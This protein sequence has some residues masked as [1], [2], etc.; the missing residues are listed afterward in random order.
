[1]FGN[2][3]TSQFDKIRPMNTTRLRRFQLTWHLATRY[4]VRQS[5]KVS[6]S[7]D[8]SQNELRR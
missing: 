3:D 5:Y 6:C 8:S 1:M 7:C 2:R 4:F